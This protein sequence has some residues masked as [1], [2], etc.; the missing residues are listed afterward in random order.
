MTNTIH[1][2][3]T[4]ESPQGAY[5][6]IKVPST[7]SEGWITK[8]MKKKTEIYTVF[9]NLKH[10]RQI[11]PTVWGLKAN[12]I[13]HLFLI[14]LY[15]FHLATLAFVGCRVC[16][17]ISLHFPPFSACRLQ[18][19]TCICAPSSS[20]SHTTQSRLFRLV[21]TAVWFSL[22]S[23]CKFSNKNLYSLICLLSSVLRSKSMACQPSASQSVSAML[24]FHLWLSDSPAS[25]ASS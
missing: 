10:H 17:C 12:K 14:S 1:L 23:M 16:V 2:I 3:L 11:P 13:I 19:L 7:K 24:F 20:P 15:F 25:Q 8:N 22:F 4:Y 18:T 5:R 9:H 6:T 21:F